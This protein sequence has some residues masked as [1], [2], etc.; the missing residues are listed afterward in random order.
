MVF[1]D[2]INGLDNSVIKIMAI[3]LIKPNQQ[4][5]YVTEN[6]S[7]R[8]SWANS[9]TTNLVK[10]LHRVVSIDSW[11]YSKNGQLL[12][13]LGTYDPIG[14][15][16]PSNRF[17]QLNF[18]YYLTDYYNE[19]KLGFA[20]A[21]S[22]ASEHMLTHMFDPEGFPKNYFI[23]TREDHRDANYSLSSGV[24]VHAFGDGVITNY[25]L[26]ASI[27]QFPRASVSV[28]CLNYLVDDFNA[29]DW[30]ANPSTYENRSSDS[31]FIP[32]P[33]P[34]HSDD[35]PKILKPGDISVQI[36]N[37]FLD[38]NKETILIQ[39]F[40]FSLP[41]GRASYYKFGRDNPESRTVIKPAPYSCS[42]EFYARDLLTGNLSTE[43]FCPTTGYDID[44]LFKNCSGDSKIA[45]SFRNLYLESMDH[46]QEANSRQRSKASFVSQFGNTNNLDYGVY[47]F[48]G[49]S[50]ATLDRSSYNIYTGAHSGDFYSRSG[51]IDDITQASYYLRDTDSPLFS[52][53]A[54]GNLLRTSYAVPSGASGDYM[55]AMM[56]SNSPLYYSIDGVEQSYSIIP[57][58]S[59]SLNILFSGEY[60][61]TP[62]VAATI[63]SLDDYF[64]S[65]YFSGTNRTGTTLILSDNADANYPVIVLVSQNNGR[66]S[67]KKLI[68]GM[69][70]QKVLHG[71]F[72]TGDPPVVFA[73]LEN[74]NSDPFLS[75]F[76]SEVNNRYTKIYMSS[77]V[78]T[79][80][81][82]LN[83]FTL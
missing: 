80:N 19:S 3:P 44:I 11:G 37:N 66:S 18:N 82:Y 15:A 46:Q 17:A 62:A 53:G 33:S 63:Q 73:S 72:F 75:V 58:G 81:Y 10:Q 78:P 24:K 60:T 57:S 50:F 74:S 79:P 28:E 39:S 32:D 49:F 14:F 77:P 22:G 9:G 1:I 59:N 35:Q 65:Y 61:Q 31:I 20:L 70:T 13:Q 56:V 71:A 40:D 2:L 41:L 8:S 5:L 43:S 30:V 23:L 83:V 38:I 48:S 26:S 7:Y 54:S 34:S 21:D 42:I 25:S 12:S 52:Y 27:N 55:Y 69:Y 64:F 4:A 29:G 6:E 51:V 47:L 76:P 45:F 67:R 68:S 36:S 16:E